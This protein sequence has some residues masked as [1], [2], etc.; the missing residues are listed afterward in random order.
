MKKKKEKVLFCFFFFLFNL[1]FGSLT[2]YNYTRRKR[3]EC[4]MGFGIFYLFYN[5]FKTI[6]IVLK[7]LGQSDDA[8]DSSKNARIVAGIKNMLG[9]DEDNDMGSEEKKLN[10]VNFSNEYN[11]DSINNDNNN[12]DNNNN[13][14]NDDGYEQ[15]Q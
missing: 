5:F 14:D 10:N 12:N 8:N 1:F 11:N 4:V 6:G 13:D 2:F 7:I 9:K 15:E 3:T